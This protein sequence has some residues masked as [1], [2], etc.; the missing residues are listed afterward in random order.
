MLSLCGFNIF[1][2]IIGIATT[3]LKTRTG[4]WNI[5]DMI[6]FLL[7]IF[8]VL[9]FSCML[10]G[11]KVGNGKFIYPAVYVVP[12]YIL[13][14]LGFLIYTLIVIS[15]NVGSSFHNFFM[16]IFLGMQ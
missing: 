2:A 15:V 5:D 3:A 16:G 4:D 8:S 7:N 13:F 1:L 9:M 10:H 11:V 6:T 14:D 12:V